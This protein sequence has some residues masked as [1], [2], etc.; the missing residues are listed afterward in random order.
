MLIAMTYN[1]YIMISIAVGAGLAYLLFGSVLFNVTAQ[2]V[3]AKMCQGC[4][5]RTAGI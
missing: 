1:A 5:L 2:V 3:A 4:Q